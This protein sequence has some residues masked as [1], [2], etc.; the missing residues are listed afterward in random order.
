MIVS[1]KGAYYT[2]VEGQ[3]LFDGLSGLW[4]SPLGHRH[5]KIVEAVKRQL[6][7]ADYVPALQ[8]A[9]PESFRLAERPPTWRRGDLN[10]VFFTN[11]GSEAVDTSLKIALAYHRLRGR[12]LAHALH[13]PREGLPWRR[14]RR[15]L[16][17]RHGREPQDVRAGDDPRR[18]PSAAYAQPGGN[19]VLARPCRQ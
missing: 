6:D 7:I 3:Q 4:C 18:R 9:S 5:P 16:G 8:V 13:R 12:S 19:G 17:R 10:R 11:S 15:H 1:A 2:T 14:L